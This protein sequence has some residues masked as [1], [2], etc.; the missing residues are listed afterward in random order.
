MELFKSVQFEF[1]P[2]ILYFLNRYPLLED[3][4]DDYDD[5]LKQ[6]RSLTLDPIIQ[7]RIWYEFCPP[8]LQVEVAPEF[9]AQPRKLVSFNFYTEPIGLTQEDNRHI[10]YGANAYTLFVNMFGNRPYK[11]LFDYHNILNKSPMTVF[12]Y[13]IWL[14]CLSDT[15]RDYFIS[16]KRNYG[17][18]LIVEI[19]VSDLCTS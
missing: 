19:Q 3:E 1:T 15:D 11:Y 7:Q 10:I 5:Q 14:Y 17:R 12:G 13:I 18:D 8:D 16:E 4:K 6:N 9:G 2:T